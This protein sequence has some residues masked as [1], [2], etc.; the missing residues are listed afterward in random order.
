MFVLSIC[1]LLGAVAADPAA[2][3][4]L[5]EKAEPEIRTGC[6]V[7]GG[8]YLT[9]PYIVKRAGNEVFINDR[10]IRWFA[11]WPIPKPIVSRSSFGDSNFAW[12]AR[13]I[14]AP[15]EA[16]KAQT[17]LESQQSTDGVCPRRTPRRANHLCPWEE[18][19]YRFCE[20]NSFHG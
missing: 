1:C 7:Y 15:I 12:A 6:V 10:S 13:K 9:P 5:G 20:R 2:I 8:E 18:V 14:V 3:E 17:R 19:F 11:P 16:D 4:F